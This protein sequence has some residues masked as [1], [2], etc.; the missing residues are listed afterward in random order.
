MLTML[1]SLSSALFE[2][3]DVNIFTFTN[4]FCPDSFF[5]SVLKVYETLLHNFET[6]P[7]LKRLN[8]STFG[9]PAPENK[10]LEPLF[11][12][13]ENSRSQAHSGSRPHENPFAQGGAPRMHCFPDEAMAGQLVEMGFARDAAERVLSE[14]RN[15]LEQ[16][17]GLLLR[18][19]AAKPAEEEKPEAIPAS[20][21]AE[22][23]SLLD[24][25]ASLEVGEKVS[26]EE[27]FIR[28]IT[29]GFKQ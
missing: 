22:M 26:Y 23:K 12:F 20:T 5:V 29:S 18:E 14:T 27:Q 28:Q 10:P 3:Q 19:Q 15:H 4:R 9:Q 8:V 11:S 13:G 17:I 6:L 24:K 25:I 2:R 7:A 1:S 21:D 16:S